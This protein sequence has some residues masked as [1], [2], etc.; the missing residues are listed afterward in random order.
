MNRK[1]YEEKLGL[2][3]KN[4]QYIKVR[5][6]DIP[7]SSRMDVSFVCDVCNVEYVAKKNTQKEPSNNTYCSKECHREGKRIK[8][9]ENNPN[10]RNRI[11]VNCYNCGLEYETVPSK[12][13]IQDNFSCSRECYKERRKSMGFNLLNDET[14]IE[15]KVREYLEEINVEF[16]TQKSVYPYWCDF[17]IPKYNLIIEAYGDY[18]HANP[19]KYGHEDADDK[20]KSLW[21]DDI[22]RINYIIEKGYRVEI[23]WGKTIIKNTEEMKKKINKYLSE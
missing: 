15:K 19:M 20:Y 2:D 7:F 3:L 22:K 5:Q 18:W 17:Y 14:N 6:G 13:K 16:E 12:Y 9:I 1:Y 8:M 4:G 10:P 21:R 11:L 23:L